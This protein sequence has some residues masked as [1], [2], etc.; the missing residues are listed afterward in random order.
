LTLRGGVASRV[1]SEKYVSPQ[2][3]ANVVFGFK[4]QHFLKKYFLSK[5]HQKTS[6]RV[7]GLKAF[8]G[9]FPLIEDPR[10]MNF[11]AMNHKIF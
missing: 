6:P 2:I 10:R 8:L 11:D 5:K 4:K 9:G 3:A 1:T 7:M